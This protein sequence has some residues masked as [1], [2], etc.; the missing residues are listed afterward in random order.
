MLRLDGASPE[1]IQES[2]EDEEMADTTDRLSAPS[3][4]RKAAAFGTFLLLRRSTD[5]EFR[6]ELL[7]VFQE[8]FILR[9]KG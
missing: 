7:V 6:V 1:P 2:T 4:L 9:I 8:V 5:C 3:S